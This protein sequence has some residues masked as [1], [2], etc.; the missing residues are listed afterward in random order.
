[1]DNGRLSTI[2]I[3]I[4]TPILGYIATNPE[5]LQQALNSLGYTDYAP[6]IIAIIITTYNLLYPR[7]ND[8]DETQN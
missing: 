7:Q 8:D 4:T 3:T 1:M 5:P 2:L 6:I